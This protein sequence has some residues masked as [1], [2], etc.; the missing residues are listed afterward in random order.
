[1]NAITELKQK[2]AAIVDKQ[3]EIIDKVDAEKREMSAEET[4]TYENMNVEFDSLGEQIQKLEKGEEL[5]A[6]LKEREEQMRERVVDREF[7]AELNAEKPTNPR[8]TEEYRTAYENYLRRGQ[9]GL[10]ADELR[11]LQVGTDSEGGYTVPDEFN[12][13]LIEAMY[14]VNVMR[15]LCTVIQTSNGT[16]DIP[17]VSSQG[18]A[19]WTAEEAAFNEADDAFGVVQLSAYKLSRIIKVSEELLNDSAFNMQ[20]YLS[21]SFANAFGSAEETAFVVGDG[22]SKPTGITAS[23][24]T[25]VTAA[26]ETAI[27]GDEVVG[28]YHSLARQYRSKAT[29]MMNDSTALLLRKLKDGNSQYLWQ[30]GLQAGDPD[31]LLGK[32]VA[33]AHDMATVATSAKAIL[34]ADLSY[35]WIA[36]RT[37]RTFQ[38]LNE[39]YAAN[40]QVGFRA[41]QR[42]DG[43]LTLAAAA[44]LLVMDD[45]T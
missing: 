35:Y 19:A 3:R 20:S 23:A 14:D 12:K 4:Q 1:M 16:M 33:I 25:G 10:F 42:V 34:F 43:K 44:K 11:A 18:A 41:A 8:D 22:S 38:R 5:R 27:T 26:S 36:D 24:G 45:G 40:G 21:N 37:G 32:P 17:V 15:P 9:N 6:Q 31:R 2:R 39:L 28:L 7:R 29:F 30:P 13:K